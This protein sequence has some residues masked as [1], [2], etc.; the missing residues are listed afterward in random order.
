MVHKF[1]TVER[2]NKIEKAV[3]VVSFQRI[4]VCFA[5]LSA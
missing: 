4:Y 1:R 3:M 5:E 2:E